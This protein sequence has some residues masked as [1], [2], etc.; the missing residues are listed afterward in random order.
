M[1][2][3][4]RRKFTK[5][6]KI[7]IIT[8]LVISTFLF[9]NRGE[10]EEYLASVES[11]NSKSKE[12]YIIENIKAV[13]QK[14]NYP[15]GC[16]SVSLYILLSHYDVDVT[17]DKIIESLPKGSVPYEEDETMFGP[18]PEKEFVGDPYTDYSYGVFEKPIK[19][20]ANKFK[21]GAISKK[22]ISIDEVKSIIKSG[23]PIIVWTRISE[24]LSKLEYKDTWINEDD[25]STI[26]KWPSGEHAVVLYGYD[27]DF[28]YISN[29]INGEKYPLEKEIFEY[30]F[31]LMG[32]RVVYYE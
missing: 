18:D 19:N 5:N 31:K 28:Y 16:E 23:S 26:I 3:K 7:F 30:N 27:E 22:D 4:K 10:N 6:F 24:D 25:N 9:F 15:T 29:P 32:S 20:V 13:R 2:R 17:I 11:L 12:E 8:L 21:K 14:P 1:K